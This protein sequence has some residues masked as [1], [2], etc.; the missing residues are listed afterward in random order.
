MDN[1]CTSAVL[2]KKRRNLLTKLGFLA[3]YDF[4]MAGGTGLALQIK[5]R[6]SL[7]FDFCT[8]QAFEPAKLKDEFNK[9]FKTVK[10]IH[11]AKDTLILEVERVMVSFFTYPYKMLEPYVKLGEINLA[12]AKD[13]AA[14]KIVAIA[15][16]GRRRDFID[17]YF[18]IEKIGLKE[19]IGSAQE[20]YPKLNIYTVL[21]GLMYFK[22]ADKDLE[23]KKLKLFEKVNW[24]KV[25]NDII[26]Q[27]KEVRPH[28]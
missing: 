7:D 16:R 21:Q 4:Y 22:D 17:M 6:T 3:G 20:K 2:D 19:I 1:L 12:S 13:I 15:Q 9:R 27:V 14:M 18:L 24:G 26:K 8:P 5:H 11:I 28:L 10:E 23:E 25:K